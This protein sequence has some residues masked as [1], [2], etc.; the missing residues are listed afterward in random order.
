MSESTV[1][2]PSETPVRDDP[3]GT[4]F[5]PGG[6]PFGGARPYLLGVVVLGGLAAVPIMLSDR[7]PD[8]FDRL[9]DWIEE[10]F[11]PDVW[12]DNKDLVPPGDVAMHLVLFG[13]LALAVGLMCWSW[14]TFALGQAGVLVGGLMLELLQPVFTDSRNVEVH[15]VV[16]N[17]AGQVAGM[18]AAL[19]LIAL[20]AR[21]RRSRAAS[22]PR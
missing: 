21:R 16:S 14:R 22:P 20:Q 17:V 9:T 10:S 11:F 2:D 5:G 7:A 4:P 8:L 6:R 3:A 1:V 19:A 15:D 13:G 12:W 18:L